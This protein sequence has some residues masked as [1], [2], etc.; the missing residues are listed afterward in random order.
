MEAGDEAAKEKENFRHKLANALEQRLFYIPSFKIYGG[1]AG[2][3]D[4]GPPAGSYI[5]L[6]N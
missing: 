2:L 1:V 4:Y 5:Y 3:Y 6:S